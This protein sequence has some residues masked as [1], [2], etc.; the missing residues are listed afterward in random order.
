LILVFFSGFL[1]LGCTEPSEDTLIENDTL[2]EPESELIEGNPTPEPSVPV[3]HVPRN[4]AHL[5]SKAYE[6]LIVS[7][8]PIKCTFLAVS[9]NELVN[10]TL[11]QRGYEYFRISIP[12]NDSS[13]LIMTGEKRYETNPQ[14]GN[15]SDSEG[16]CIW[17]ENTS[18]LEDIFFA[19]Q[20]MLPESCEEWEFDSSVFRPPASDEICKPMEIPKEVYIGDISGKTFPELPGTNRA[21]YCEFTK[22]EDSGIVQ[23]SIYMKGEDRLR[24]EVGAQTQAEESNCTEWTHIMRSDVIYFGCTKGCM[25]CEERYGSGELTECLWEKRA[26]TPFNSFDDMRAS[27]MGCRDWVFDESLFAPAHTEKVCTEEEIVQYTIE[28]M[29]GAQ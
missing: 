20:T 19:T 29:G 7:D 3:P 11:Y 28:A 12:G 4:E 15:S 22:S 21:L 6:E 27:E 16:G 5:R 18:S 10:G 26:L 1:L 24:I 14:Y 9:G 25:F 8:T 13:E 2:Q 17:I 23:Y